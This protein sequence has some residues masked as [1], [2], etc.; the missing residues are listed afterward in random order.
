L[1][2]SSFKTR[3]SAIPY[4]HFAADNPGDTDYFK[5]ILDSLDYQPSHLELVP[6]MI[7]VEGKNDFYGLKFAKELGYVS[8][9]I[10]AHISPGAGKDTLEC[11]IALYL[12]WAKSFVVL[13]D[14]DRGGRETYRQLS[15]EFGSAIEGRIFRLNHAD[16]R[17]RGAEFEDVFAKRDQLRVIKTTY[18][19]NSE[20]EKEK[21]NL[22]LQQCYFNSNKV[23]LSDFSLDRLQVLFDFLERCL[24]QQPS[25]TA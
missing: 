8:S 10:G 1:G 13:L 3:I 14:D 21:F 25:D 15:A 22:A 16:R 12:G 6:E 9:S 20:F 7:I 11:L 4:F 18:P 24:Q 17:F 19:E 5:P 2:H 23:E